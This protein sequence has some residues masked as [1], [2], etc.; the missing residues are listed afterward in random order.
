MLVRP[1]TVVNL[2]IRPYRMAA[3]AGTWICADQHGQVAMMR[4]GVVTRVE[5]PLNEVDALAIRPADGQI[6][7]AGTNQIIDQDRA[8]YLPGVAALMPDD[9]GNCWVAATQDSDTV[10]VSV[11]NR[12][13]QQ[14]ASVDVPDR[15]GDSALTLT[16][17]VDGVALDLAAGQDGC[18]VIEL[19]LNEEG[20]KQI[21]T[22]QGHTVPVLSPGGTKATIE[23]EEGI[24]LLASTGEQRFHPYPEDWF[25]EGYRVVFY[26]EDR[27]IVMLDERTYLLHLA[28]G[29]YEPFDVEGL[30][31]R[32]LPYWYP[33]LDGDEMVSPLTDLLRNG[34]QIYAT[35]ADHRP[36]H[37]DHGLAIISL[38]GDAG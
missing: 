13:W 14:I 17:M 20:L 22:A 4:D 36:G 32:P 23:L 5:C 34:D 3:A 37:C 31:A 9:E 24:W 19:R 11:W 25:A 30:E 8:I 16:G 27:L 35:F 15:F 28:T 26:D 7:L 1:E 10:Q 18:E 38:P 12:D 29:N 33:S 21:S 2:P 6:I